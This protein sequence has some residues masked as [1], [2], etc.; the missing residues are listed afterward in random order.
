M[1]GAA[2]PAR[3]PGSLVH[4]DAARRAGEAHRSG[5]AGETGADDVNRARH[6][7]KA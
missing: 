1:I 4:D 3:L 6:Q 7:T 5:K 2:T